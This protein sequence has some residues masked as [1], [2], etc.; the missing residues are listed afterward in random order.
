[1]N[2]DDGKPVWENSGFSYQFQRQPHGGSYSF[3]GIAPQGA[4]AVLGD[5]LI[6]PGGR[7]VPACF[8]RNTGAIRFFHFEG[9]PCV[10]GVKVHNK[11]E[12]GSQ[13]AAWGDFYLNHRGVNTVLYSAKTGHAHQIWNRTT[14]PVLDDGILYLSGETLEAYRLDDFRE[15]PAE[16]KPVWQLKADT[17]AALIKA[18]N[19]LYAAGKE[20]IIALELQPEGPP[21][22]AW[23]LPVEGNVVRLVAA[24]DRLFAVTLEGDLFAFGAEETAPT[25]HVDPAAKLQ[26]WPVPAAVSRRDSLTKRRSIPD[27]A[28]FSRP[29]TGKSQSNWSPIRV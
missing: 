20:E 7:S 15:K 13:L 26:E 16:A 24:A 14:Y 9:S 10:S 4:L 17:S 21:T 6:V 22:I 23:R 11:L 2:I 27:I 19:R 5:R 1:M 29:P 28:L 8:D 18:G 12:G 3:A 25:V